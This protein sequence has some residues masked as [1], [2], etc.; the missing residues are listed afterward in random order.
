MQE[1]CM[2]SSMHLIV[3]TFGGDFFYQLFMGTLLEDQKCRLQCKNI[4]S[5]VEKKIQQCYCWWHSTSDHYYEDSLL[6]TIKLHEY[7]FS[8]VVNFDGLAQASN[9]RIER[10]LLA[11]FL[12]WLQDSNLGSLRHQAC[13]YVLIISETAIYTLYCSLRSNAH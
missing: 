6:S 7:I 2:N 12:C 10:D 11:I 9:F 1:E 8:F 4:N 3:S 13:I 5:P